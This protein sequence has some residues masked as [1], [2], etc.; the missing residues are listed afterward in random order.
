MSAAFVVV[1]SSAY[2][3]EVRIISSRTNTETVVTKSSRR[4]LPNRKVGGCKIEPLVTNSN[5][6]LI[7]MLVSET[8]KSHL[9]DRFSFY[10]SLISVLFISTGP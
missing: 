5:V 7:L 4:T 2:I 6:S 9:E 8:C 3:S 10:L 1:F